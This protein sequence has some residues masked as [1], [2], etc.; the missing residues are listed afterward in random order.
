MV[1]LQDK[2]KEKKQQFAPRIL[3][4]ISV[5]TVL[6]CNTDIELCISKA[7]ITTLSQ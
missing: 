4:V 7:G 3:A 1:L 6:Q 2:V 5:S